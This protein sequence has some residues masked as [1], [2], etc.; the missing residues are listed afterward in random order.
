[1]TDRRQ[2]DHAAEKCVAIG[3]IGCVARVIPPKNWL[4]TSNFATATC[5]QN[6]SYGC[7]AIAA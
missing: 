2:T 1:V 6:Y 3:R 7:F 5:T 4:N